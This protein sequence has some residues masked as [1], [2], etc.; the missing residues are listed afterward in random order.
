MNDT[1]MAFSAGSSDIEMRVRKP[2]L[3][4]TVRGLKLK[5]ICKCKKVATVTLAATCR[6]VLCSIA[7]V[8]R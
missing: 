8:V 4:W 3:D 6:G 5:G 7:A 2:N 1:F